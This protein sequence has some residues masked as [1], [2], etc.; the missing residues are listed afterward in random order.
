MCRKRKRF[1][2]MIMAVTM[3]LGMS[4]MVSA[5]EQPPVMSEE[6]KAFLSEALYGVEVQK[7]M[8]G[9]ADVDFSELCLGEAF[10]TYVYRDEEFGKGC[11][12][13]RFWIMGN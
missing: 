4:V 1:V 3:F 7:E 2:G 8:L 12:Y 9:L 10:Q 5:E 13:I 6:E 11:V